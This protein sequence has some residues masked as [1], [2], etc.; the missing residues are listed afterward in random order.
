MTKPWTD[1]DILGCASFF[2][3]EGKKKRVRVVG[4]LSGI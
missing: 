2:G 3:I 1:D 4:N